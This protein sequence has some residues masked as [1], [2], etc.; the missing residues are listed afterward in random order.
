MLLYKV[1]IRYILRG[2]VT[3][4]VKFVTWRSCDWLEIQ[5]GVAVIR[6][7]SLPSVGINTWE[8]RPLQ[9]VEGKTSRRTHVALG[10]ENC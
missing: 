3:F 5:A 6:E 4:R 1:F 8:Y 7:S 10:S 2:R 9:P